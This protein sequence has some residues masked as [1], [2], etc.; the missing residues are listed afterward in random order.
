MWKL[1]AKVPVA[2]QH[3][4][5]CIP[6]FESRAERWTQP[7]AAEQERTGVGRAATSAHSIPFFLGMNNGRGRCYSPVN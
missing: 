6:C 3:R 4:N 5:F 2:D 7:S 1:S